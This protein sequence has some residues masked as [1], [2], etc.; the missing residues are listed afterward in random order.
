[1][2]HVLDIFNNDAFNVVSMTSAI[3]KVPNT[4]GLLNQLGIFKPVPVDTTMVGIEISEGV[5]NLVPSSERG[6]PGTPN[7]R[8]SRNMRYFKL[9]HFALEDNVTADDVQNIRAFGSG[10]KLLAVASKVLEVQMQMARKLYLTMEFMKNGAL[11][12][13]ILDSDGTVILDL[14]EL[15]GITQKEV[16]FELAVEGANL[17]E[18][19]L[20]VKEHVELHLKG[21]NMTELLALCSPGWWRKFITH[22]DVAE[23]YKYYAHSVNPL[24]SDVRSGFK[25]QDI[26]WRE[27]LGQATTHDGTV[28]YFIPPNGCLFLPLGTFD[29]FE[30]NFGPADYLEAANTPGLPLYSKLGRPDKFGKGQPI[31]AQ[32]NPLPIVKRPEV[33]V[34]G[35]F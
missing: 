11:N 18:P 31:E 12:G 26:L 34:K 23:A 35:T 10:S 16:N 20:D 24:T 7:K 27:Y 15:F 14:W 6:A 3:N 17:I 25:H 32:T 1:M 2:E 4:F 28:R 13:Q 33:L 9:P 5:I 21:E 22:P 30:E 19:C 8:G 29:T